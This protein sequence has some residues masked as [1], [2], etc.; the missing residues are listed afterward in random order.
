MTGACAGLVPVARQELLRARCVTGLTEYCRA[1][2][3]SLLQYR[4]EN[5]SLASSSRLVGGQATPGSCASG[6]TGGDELSLRSLPGGQRSLSPVC[7]LSGEEVTAALRR[8]SRRR[9]LE[10]QNSENSSLLS[11]EALALDQVTFT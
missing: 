2:A 8:S 11:G 6:E 3:G 10:K 4:V 7:C 1:L 9:V 5:A